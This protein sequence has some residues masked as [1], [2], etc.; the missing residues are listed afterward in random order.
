MLMRAKLQK[1]LEELKT[2]LNRG[3]LRLLELEEQQTTIR[4]T[5]VR[6]AGAIQLLE[7]LLI[8]PGDG[9]DATT[10]AEWSESHGS[11]RPDSD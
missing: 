2:E 3:R 9:R 7:E 11:G 5:L 4:T 8:V 10:L 1:R 6:I